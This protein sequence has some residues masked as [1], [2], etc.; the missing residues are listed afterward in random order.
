MAASTS[1]NKILI[2]AIILVLI[3]GAIYGL[4]TMPDRRTPSEKLGDAVS[5][6]DKGVDKAAQEL[7][8]RTPAERLGDAVRDAEDR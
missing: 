3:S 8:D 1:D 7:G 5:E 2:T 4:L 6:L